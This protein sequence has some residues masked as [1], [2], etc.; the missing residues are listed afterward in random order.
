MVLRNTYFVSYHIYN[1]ISILVT[2]WTQGLSMTKCTFDFPELHL[3][4]FYHS[5]FKAKFRE[6]VYKML[7]YVEFY[8]SFAKVLI[9][10]SVKYGNSISQCLTISRILD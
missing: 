3:L 10:Q 8:Y 9:L 2:K 6:K 4:K 1:G 7:L 5:Y